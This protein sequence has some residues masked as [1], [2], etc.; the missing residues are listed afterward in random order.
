MWAFLIRN[1]NLEEVQGS[2]KRGMIMKGDL[3]DLMG[4]KPAPNLKKI[5]DGPEE[6]IKMTRLRLTIAKRLKEAQ[7]NAAMLTTFNEVDM[8]N[9][10]DIRPEKSMSAPWLRVKRNT[11]DKNKTG[12]QI[13]SIIIVLIYEEVDKRMKNICKT[14]KLINSVCI[15]LWIPF[16]NVIKPIQSYPE[17]PNSRISLSTFCPLKT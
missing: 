2:G 7:N 1:I 6:R 17:S 16:L 11:A 4:S 12:S 9:I 13:T 15:A 14:I 5:K 3:I 10:I 8:F